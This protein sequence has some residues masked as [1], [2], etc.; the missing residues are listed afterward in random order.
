MLP[1]S[2]NEAISAL[3]RGLTERAV[4]K[5]LRNGTGGRFAAASECLSRLELARIVDTAGMLSENRMI[6]STF[7]PKAI[8]KLQTSGKIRESETG[9]TGAS[10]KTYRPLLLKLG[11]ITVSDD[12]D[13]LWVWVG[14]ESAEWHT[15]VFMHH[16][17]RLAKTTAD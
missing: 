10:L 8:E 16:N 9:F 4:Q 13:S 2:R 14:P 6:R 11:W 17:R 1:C 3:V 15:V 7:G 12:H 5:A